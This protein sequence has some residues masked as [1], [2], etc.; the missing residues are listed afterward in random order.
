MLAAKKA[1]RIPFRWA[2]DARNLTTDVQAAPAGPCYR[3]AARSARRRH[4]PLRPRHRRL[5]LE[6]TVLL[7][8]AGNRPHL[9]RQ[10]CAGLAR[11]GHNAHWTDDVC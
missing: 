3:A 7:T 1:S 8:K 10:A 6:A 5:A 2:L 11:Y 4:E 9:G